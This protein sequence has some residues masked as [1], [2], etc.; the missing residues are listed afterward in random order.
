MKII[1]VKNY[2]EMS[3]EALKI[4]LNV[5]KNKPNARSKSGKYL[6]QEKSQQHLNATRR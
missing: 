5:V 3:E 4:V 6:S 1:K 2:D